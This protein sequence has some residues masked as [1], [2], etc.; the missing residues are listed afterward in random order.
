MGSILNVPES[1]LKRH[2]FPGPGLA[3]R[4]LGDVTEGNALEILRQV[5]EI[6]IQSIKEAGLYDSIWQ[7][8]AVFLPVQSVGVQG[9]QRTH[10]HVVVLRAITSE[11][12]MTADW[13][14]H[15]QDDK[16]L[17]RNVQFKMHTKNP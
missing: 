2:P 5:D 3:V 17:S 8:F 15:N 6:F 11:D 7:A 9:D 14:F 10:S 1:F 4:V 16:L 13:S 12:G